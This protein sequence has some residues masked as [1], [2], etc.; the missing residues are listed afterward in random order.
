MPSS[1]IDLGSGADSRWPAQA[2]NTA[3]YIAAKLLLLAAGGRIA[4][5]VGY[6][7]W[8]ERER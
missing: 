2:A 8:P 4:D 6:E 1:S 5:A 7:S 3:V